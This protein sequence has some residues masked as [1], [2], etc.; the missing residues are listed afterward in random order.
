MVKGFP[1]LDPF[2]QMAMPTQALTSTSPYPYYQ[3]LV[4][5]NFRGRT[6]HSPPPLPLPFFCLYTWSSNSGSWV[7]VRTGVSVLFKLFQNNNRNQF[8]LESPQPQPRKS[9]PPNLYNGGPNFVNLFSSNEVSCNHTHTL[10]LIYASANRR[11]FVFS[12]VTS[13]VGKFT[14]DTFSNIII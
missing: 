5:S 10:V 13:L 3:M 2:K 12:K 1:H 4:H 7:S 9:A 6:T 11:V 8:V 14:H